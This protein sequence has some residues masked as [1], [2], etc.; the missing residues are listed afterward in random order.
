MINEQLKEL[1]EIIKGKYSELLAA[2]LKVNDLIL[3]EYQQAT[4]ANTFQ[5]FKQW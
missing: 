3:M 5:T 1:A 2:G 4:G